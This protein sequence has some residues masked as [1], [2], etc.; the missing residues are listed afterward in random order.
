MQNCARAV[1]S[2]RCRLPLFYAPPTKL[3]HLVHVFVSNQFVWSLSA[4]AAN[5]LD[6]QFV[7]FVGSSSNR[8]AGAFTRTAT[9]CLELNGKRFSKIGESI[10]R[11]WRSNVLMPNT[12]YVSAAPSADGFNWQ[13]KSLA[14]A[15]CLTPSV[16]RCIAGISAADLNE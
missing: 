14:R 5:V 8:I 11:R 15:E 9:V 10:G 16:L 4:F 1:L 3:S 7:Q 2:V 13:L 12:T 6:F